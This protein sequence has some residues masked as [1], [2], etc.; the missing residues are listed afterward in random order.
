M[1]GKRAI[2]LRSVQD[3]RKLLART[4]NSFWRDEI[5]PEKAGKIGYLCNI[6]VKAFEQDDFESRLEGLEERLLEDRS[7][8]VDW[9]N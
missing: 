1:A 9:N 2:R 4:I 5:P 7:A 3:V 6:L 8:N